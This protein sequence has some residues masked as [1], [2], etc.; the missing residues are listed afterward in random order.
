MPYHRRNVT[1]SQLL[2]ISAS[3]FRP[4]GE[5]LFGIEC[6]WPVTDELDQRARADMDRLAAVSQDP[7]PAGGRITIEPGGQIELSS[8]PASCV[9]NAIDATA[10]DA[11]ILHNRL[12]SVGLHRHETALDAARPP[13]RVLVHPRYAAMQ[14]FFD[15]EGPAGRWMMC[16]TASVQINVSNDNV[17]PLARWEI[18]NRIAPALLAAFA[19]SRGVDASGTQW[20][21]LRQGIWNRIDPGRTR[22][23][24]LGKPAAEAWLQYALDANVLYVL[25]EGSNGASGTGILPGMTFGHWMRYGSAFGWPTVED[26]R[27]HLTTLFPPIRPRGWMEVRVLDGLPTRW[28]TAATVAV[29]V[30]SQTH[31]M[32]ELRENVPDVS[33][34]YN[35]AAQQGLKH[36]TLLLAARSI[37]DI[38]VRNV[39]SV[40]DR[41]EHTDALVDFAERY[42][43]RGR[44][45]GDE[46][47]HELPIALSGSNQRPAGAGGRGNTRAGAGH[48]R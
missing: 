7:L 10:M 36:P 43:S 1:V 30:A 19:N 4:T 25:D 6:E 29:A 46:N 26:F 47:W 9:S 8:F 27:Y 11:G 14:E 38:L 15:S 5:D 32:Q 12:R 39:R 33:H 17:E 22:P 37:M 34:L 44:C 45:P 18:L 16:N 21:S 23:V 13:Q 35:E 41:T 20:A 3:M 24:D 28:I 48:R 2:E 42:T 31:V 40:S